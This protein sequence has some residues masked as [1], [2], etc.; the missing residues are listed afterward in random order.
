[1][2]QVQNSNPITTSFLDSVKSSSNVGKKEEIDPQDRFL[3]LLVTQMKN[4]NPLKPLD[5]AEVTSQ[6]AQIS[7]VTGIEKLNTT[8]QSL[9]TDSNSRRAVDAATMIGREV[10]VPGSIMKLENGEGLAGVELT[11]GADKVTVTIKDSVGV[12]VREIDLGAQPAGI[13]PIIWNGEAES[14][15]VAANGNYKFTVSAWRDGQEINV[16]SLAVGK[17][18]SVSTSDKGPTLDVGE[19]GHVNLSDIKQIL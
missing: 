9:V 10:L 12:K 15:T 3:K 17:V 6:I 4:Q 2:S 7:T 14:G 19:L 8:L 16:K 5:N 13:N 11:E 18:E 1:M